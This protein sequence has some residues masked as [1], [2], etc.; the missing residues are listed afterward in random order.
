MLD[1]SQPTV[2]YEDRVTNKNGP[3]LYVHLRRIIVLLR[4]SAYRGR[5]LSVRIKQ[6]RVLLLPANENN[7]DNVCPGYQTSQIANLKTKIKNRKDSHNNAIHCVHV[8]SAK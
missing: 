6:R 7:L 4:L 1:S 5:H 2:L 3:K 8:V